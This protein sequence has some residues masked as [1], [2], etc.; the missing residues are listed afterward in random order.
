MVSIT[1]KYSDPVHCNNLLTEIGLNDTQIA[2]LESDGFTTMEVLVSHH[3]TGGASNLEKYIC[4]LNKTFAN[5]FIAL[6]VY[7]NPVIIK[8]LCSCLTYFLLCIYSFHTISD[9]ELIDVATLGNLDSFWTKSNAN[10]KIKTNKSDE[11]TNIDLPK[12]K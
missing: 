6:R 3:Q 1:N 4:G 8:C 9:I 5:A 11:N 10:K 12:L 2:R 7:Y